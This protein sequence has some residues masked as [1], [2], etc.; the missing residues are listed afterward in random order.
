MYKFHAQFH[1]QYSHSINNVVMISS[2]SGFFYAYVK[3]TVPPSKLRSHY[4]PLYIKKKWDRWKKRNA[5][6]LKSC[7]YSLYRL[8]ALFTQ[9]EGNESV[10]KKMWEN[11]NEVFFLLVKMINLTWSQLVNWKHSIEIFYQKK[12]RMNR[13]KIL[14]FLRVGSITNQ[15]LIYLLILCGEKKAEILSKKKTK[16]KIY[17]QK[18]TIFIRILQI[19]YVNVVQV[20]CMIRWANLCTTKKCYSLISIHISFC[21]S[22]GVG[23]IPMLFFL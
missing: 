16:K 22:F 10:Y 5:S 4:F 23:F 13:K 20:L 6:L 12:K 15:P 11:L 18:K 8:S 2:T 3:K 21:F 14:S 9:F 1:H 17:G 7:T 19:E